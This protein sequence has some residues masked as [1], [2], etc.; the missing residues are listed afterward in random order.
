MIFVTC[1]SAQS[2]VYFGFVSRFIRVGTVACNMDEPV[3]AL[4]LGED[5]PLRKKGCA[6]RGSSSR[7]HVLCLVK[8]A[9]E[10]G[11]NGEYDRWRKC[12]ICNQDFTG[13]TFHKLANM[14]WKH[15][16]NRSDEEDEWSLSAHNLA[17][18]LIDRRKHKKAVDI[19]QHVLTVQKEMYGFDHRH[20]LK[21]RS[22]LGRLLTDMDEN[23]EAET[24]LRA[25]LI[26]QQRVLEAEHE[27]TLTTLSTLA[28]SLY[29]QEKYTEAEQM[30]REALLVQKQVLGVDHKDTLTNMSNLANSLC[31]QK[32]YTEAEEM[33]REALLVQ[34]RV[35]GPEHPNTLLSTENL[36]TLLRLQGKCDGQ[37][38]RKHRSGQ[39][40]PRP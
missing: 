29:Y 40:Y 36:N 7:A 18:S 13:H 12:E 14:W 8:N 9:Q 15:V 34:K 28:I 32:K 31:M 4:C 3:C 2:A 6:C 11:R 37:Q 19:M 38:V 26:V 5:P 35:L 17:T 30:M 21:T 22:F 24:L 16:R 25:V 1:I 23:A 10:K 27:E 33:M 39:C 20:T